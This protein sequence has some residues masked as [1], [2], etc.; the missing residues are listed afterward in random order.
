MSGV[1]TSSLSLTWSLINWVFLDYEEPNGLTVRPWAP[2]PLP[3]IQDILDSWWR[4]SGAC[5]SSV[6]G[7]EC[8]CNRVNLKSCTW[9]ASNS[10]NSNTGQSGFNGERPWLRTQ[11]ITFHQPAN[12]SLIL[13][14]WWYRFR[15]VLRLGS[16]D[17]EDGHE[18][19]TTER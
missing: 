10:R 8:S 6:I 3:R 14:W 18:L 2:F 17:E 15:R 16:L 4:W 19:Y 1:T 5:R 9:P 12:R 13:A 11:P 7:R